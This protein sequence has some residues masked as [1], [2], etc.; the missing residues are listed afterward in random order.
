MNVISPEMSINKELIFN[1]VSTPL[2]T[3]KGSR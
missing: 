3:N 1:T 2:L